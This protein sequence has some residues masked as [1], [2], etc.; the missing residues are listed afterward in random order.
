M[1]KSLSALI[2]IAL[3]GCNIGDLEIDNLKGPT[4]NSRVAVPIGEVTYT[5]R[6]LLD[7]LGDEELGLQEDSTSLLKLTYFDTATFSSASEVIAIDDITNSASINIPAVP[8]A[9]D[10][11]QEVID[12]VFTFQYPASE[13]EA[14][15]SIFYSEGIM[16]LS[17]NSNVSTEMAYSLDISNTKLV[18]SGDPVNFSGNLSSFGSENQSQDLADHKTELLFENGTNTFQVAARFTLFLAPGASTSAGESISMTITYANQS[19]DLLYGKFGQDTLDVGDEELDIG[20]FKDLGD[21]G[22]RFGNPQIKFSFDNTFGLPLGILFNRMYGVDSTSRGYDTTFLSGDVTEVP[23]L[24]SGSPSPTIAATSTI[25]LDRDNSTLQDFLAGSPQSIGFD[26]RAIA[27]PEDGNASNFVMDSSRI[28]TFIEI[29]LP[30]ELALNDAVQNVDF[31]LGSGLQFDEADSVTIR[32]VSENELPLAAELLLSIV[33]ENDSVL[34]TAPEALILQIP[35]LDQQGGLSQ[36]RQLTTDIPVSSEG[37]DALATG[38]KMKLA[39][40]M[41]TPQGAG[42]GDFFVKI[43][44]DY[45]LNVK[46][47]VIGRL[48]IDL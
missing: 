37:I 38:K 9:P 15:D 44:A 17:I 31:D 30:M 7:E 35:F 24:I 39:L 28:T 46:V 11:R 48:N 43:L 12:T 19:F 22:L 45:S 32:V 47:A 6:E 42:T 5:M 16:M 2:L 29:T 8:A 34:Y 20:F 21:K 33:D 40:T 26:L 4:L 14:L 3:I 25:M 1:K 13:N 23:Q 27:N 41:N 10:S 18:S 36:V